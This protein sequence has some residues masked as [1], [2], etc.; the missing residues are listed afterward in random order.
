M[1]NNKSQLHSPIILIITLVS[2]CRHRTYED[3][4]FILIVCSDL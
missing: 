2:D 3:T 4:V 1:K